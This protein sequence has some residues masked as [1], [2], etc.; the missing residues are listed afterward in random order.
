MLKVKDALVIL[1]CT[2]LLACTSSKERADEAQAE[3]A[4][5]QAE[6]TEEKTKTLQEY[7]ECA[8]DAEGDE[9]KMAAC[10]GL[11]RA[12]EAVEGGASGKP[13]SGE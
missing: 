6:Y 4:E 7:K 5:A 3:A 13:A 2:G 9:K 10:D 12:V 8:K 11:L 1:A